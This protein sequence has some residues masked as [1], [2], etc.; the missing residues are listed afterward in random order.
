MNTDHAIHRDEWQAR[1]IKKYYLLNL[2]SHRLDLW[3]WTE[4]AD[5]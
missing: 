3:E 2:Y 4:Q 5:V 1:I